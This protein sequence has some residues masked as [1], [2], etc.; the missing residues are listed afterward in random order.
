MLLGDADEIVQ[1]L[2]A[3]LGKGWTLP[4]PL[5]EGARRPNSK[6]LT[7]QP[8]VAGAAI[9]EGPSSLRKKS[10]TRSVS[11]GGAS[12]STDA[13]SE[14]RKAGDGIEGPVVKDSSTTTL[15]EPTR[16]GAR[17]VVLVFSTS[18]FGRRRRNVLADL[19]VQAPFLLRVDECKDRRTLDA[20]L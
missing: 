18:S 4:P 9:I 12:T 2:C 7:G 15:V 13:K 8:I 19:L 10:S 1:Y 14:K 16:I 17:C 3:R 5:A 11:S 6:E 20:R